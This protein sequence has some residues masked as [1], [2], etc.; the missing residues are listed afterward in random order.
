M[1]RIT[2]RAKRLSNAVIRE[3]ITPDQFATLVDDGRSGDFLSLLQITGQHALLQSSQNAIR[4]FARS[5][6]LQTFIG[7]SGFWYE[8]ALL[9]EIAVIGL[10]CRRAGLRP[11]DYALMADVIASSTAMDAI[12][13][14]PAAMG[15][16]FGNSTYR[17]AA[18]ESVV[19]MNAIAASQ[20]AMGLVVASSDL[21]TAIFA[22]T[23]SRSIILAS[24]TAMTEVAASATAM[25]VVCGTAAYI[26]AAINTP[27]A[28]EKI[29]E[30]TTAMD[31]I[32][33]S[34][35]AK[36]E[37]YN[38][39]AALT[40]I[41]NSTTAMTRMRA[42][43]TVYSKAANGSTRVSLTSGVSPSN[44]SNSGK[45]ICLGVGGGL[46]SGTV[47]YLETRRSGSGRPHIANTTG[48]QSS[49]ATAL[50]C[51]PVTGTLQFFAQE[52]AATSTTRFSMLRCDV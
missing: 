18:V 29:A 21:V 27:T 12:A 20:A 22:N 33:A 41:F 31:A 19:A 47:I 23:V 9:D 46:S 35:V 11:E 32:T 26:Q 8:Q 24:A 4:G 36:T 25:G 15:I 52:V 1:P 40:S 16:I 38:S 17:T 48:H 45:Y 39:D 42:A 14:S 37:V 51:C 44:L 6:S 5:A 3:T 28:M 34:A 7:S 49:A 13:A 50:M 43:A 30:S 10:I 2:I